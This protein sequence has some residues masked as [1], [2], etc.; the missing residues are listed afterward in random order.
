MIKGLVVVLLVLLNF[1]SYSQELDNT[2]KTKKTANIHTA[3]AGSMFIIYL[4]D[5]DKDP[6]IK[7]VLIFST[8]IAIILNLYAIHQK[9]IYQAKRPN[10]SNNLETGG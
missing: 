7:N 2:H 10:A 1:N 4:V 6:T 8:L 5:E 3:F 9:N